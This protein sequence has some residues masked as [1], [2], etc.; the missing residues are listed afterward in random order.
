LGQRHDQD[1]FSGAQEA[2]GRTLNCTPIVHLNFGTY[3]R[4]RPAKTA[5]RTA[6]PCRLLIRKRPEVQVLAG[7]PRKA[8]GQAGSSDLA[9]CFRRPSRDGRAAKRAAIASTCSPRAPAFCE[10]VWLVT[11]AGECGAGT[12]LGTMRFSQPHD[13]GGSPR[14]PSHHPRSQPPWSPSPTPA[15]TDP[16]RPGAPRRRPPATRGQGSAR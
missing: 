13:H 7:P 6:V 5:F 9:P 12:N 16:L 4:T 10:C 11:N 2:L 8:P 14:L 3:G 1:D 15:H